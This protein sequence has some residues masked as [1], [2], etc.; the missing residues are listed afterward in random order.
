[1]E[2]DDVKGTVIYRLTEG[3]KLVVMI[4][5]TTIF[6]VALVF[7][8]VH[9]TKEK[10]DSST[11]AIF[12]TSGALFHICAFFVPIQLSLNEKS[13]RSKWIY[14]AVGGAVSL[15]WTTQLDGPMQPSSYLLGLAVG[16]LT[17][18][19]WHLLSLILKPWKSNNA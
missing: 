19:L 15:F 7:F 14:A 3:L 8:A 1:M 2:D 4:S 11:I 6:A 13:P 10:M 16:L 18:S 5:V 9:L 17:G 12:A